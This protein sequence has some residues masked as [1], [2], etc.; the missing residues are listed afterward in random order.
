MYGLVERKRDKF[1]GRL[2]RI[3]VQKLLIRCVQLCEWKDGNE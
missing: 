3:I 2:N 1:N